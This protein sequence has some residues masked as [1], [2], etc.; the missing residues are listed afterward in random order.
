MTYGVPAFDLPNA[1][2]YPD[3][4]CGGD[5]TRSLECPYERCILDTRNGL[6][7]QRKRV[8]YREIVEA[9]RRGVT[10]KKIAELFRCGERTIWRVLHDYGQAVKV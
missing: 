7:A 4:G 6:S 5:C 1:H 2:T 3:T 9:R 8:M 10:V